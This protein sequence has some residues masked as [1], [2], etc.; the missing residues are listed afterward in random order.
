MRAAAIPIAV[1]SLLIAGVVF[2]FTLRG[3]GPVDDPWVK[4]PPPVSPTDHHHLIKGPFNDGPSVT[5]ACLECHPDAARQLMKTSHWSWA[6][7]KVKLPGRE[8]VIAVGKKNLINNFCIA[9]GPNIA[10][11]SACHAG[12]GSE[13]SQI[14]SRSNGEV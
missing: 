11:C 5:R 3:S 14:S 9:A 8:E 12:Y 2:A 6:G 7:Q 4:V 13:L 10:A 1:V